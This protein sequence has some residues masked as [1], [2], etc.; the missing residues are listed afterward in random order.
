[1]NIKLIATREGILKLNIKYELASES[2]NI[3][4]IM[5]YVLDF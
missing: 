1:M 5:K 3:D 4:K 2:P